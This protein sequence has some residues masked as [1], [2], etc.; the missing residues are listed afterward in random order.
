LPLE[1]ASQLVGSWLSGRV[2]SLVISEDGPGFATAILRITLAVEIIRVA[3]VVVLEGKD[4]NHLTYSR[5]PKDNN[6]LLVGPE[7]H[8][9]QYVQE[10]RAPFRKETQLT[11]DAGLVTCILTST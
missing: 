1:L 7:Y 11:V 4:S 2:L 3:V 8:S 9:L 6:W 10:R 5:V